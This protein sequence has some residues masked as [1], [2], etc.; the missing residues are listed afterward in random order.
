[1]IIVEFIM[2]K[3]CLEKE[4]GIIHWI[5]SHFH[6]KMESKYELIIPVPVPQHGLV[7]THT[8]WTLINNALRRTETHKQSLHFHLTVC[9]EK[10]AVLSKI[11]AKIMASAICH[12]VPAVYFYR[13]FFVL[14]SFFF[15]F[16]SVLIL[17]DG[18]LFFRP[19]KKIF[20]SALPS[21]SPHKHTRKK[22][23]REKER[24]FIMISSI[25]FVHKFPSGKSFVGFRI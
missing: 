19:E 6:F 21:S 16:F 4:M 12:R 23:C 8:L 17:I 11:H 7:H 20:A 25:A 22:M 9:F 18:L 5:S 2:E 3:N 24:K 14:S 13:L 10:F 15:S 1:M